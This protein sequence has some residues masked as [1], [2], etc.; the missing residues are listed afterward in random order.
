MQYVVSKVTSN[1]KHAVLYV[2]IRCLLSAS[3][4]KLTFSRNLTRLKFSRFVYLNAL[5]FKNFKTSNET[6]CISSPYDRKF[7]FIALYSFFLRLWF[8]TFWISFRAINMFLWKT[9]KYKLVTLCS[10]DHL[11]TQIFY[12]IYTENCQGK[13]DLSKSL[14]MLVWAFI[15]T[16]CPRGRSFH[17]FSGSFPDKSWETWYIRGEIQTPVI[18][19]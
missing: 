4:V 15:L 8:N 10:H 1:C 6:K 13:L 5:A 17:R 9:W 14:W 19:L 3:V 12:S 7:I 2:V 16:S 11:F 18:K